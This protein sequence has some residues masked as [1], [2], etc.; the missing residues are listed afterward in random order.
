[1][2]EQYD[3]YVRGNTILAMPQDAGLVRV[4]E[5][6]SLGVALAVD[7]NGR[8]T[9]LDPY[10]GAQLALAEAYR[11]VA[12]TGARPLAVTN[13]LNF[14][15][16]EDPAVMWQFTEAVRGLADAC[17]ALGVPVTGGNVSF[18]NQTA[19]A[20]IHPTPVVG[21]LGVHDDVRTR[22]S[23]GFRRPGC[24]L[25]LLGR[26]Q[27]ELGGSLWAHVAH[28]HLGGRPPAVDLEAERGLAAVLAGASRRGLLD[29]A[30]DL[31]DGGLAVGL[32]ECCL[33]GGQGCT[34]RLP[35][36]PPGGEFALLFGES[37]ARAVVAV[38][39]GAEAEFA[40]LCQ[41]G[42]VPAGVLGVT[43]GAS[44]EVT[45]SFAVPLEELA[46]AHR[47]TLPGLFG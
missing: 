11:N 13:C 44:L 41:D 19:D 3:R 24:R 35:E 17:Q 30:H 31:S 34:V 27:P 8:Y 15:S 37:A 32:A 25:M 12:A 22:L 45:G 29:A 39:A 36:G 6:T 9:R 38:R 7:G 2:T 33:A 5:Q 10:A 23:I 47:A 26:S 40:A 18:Y 21:V 28:G 42:G 46:A 1:V 20:A 14:G 43:G 16:P 4:D